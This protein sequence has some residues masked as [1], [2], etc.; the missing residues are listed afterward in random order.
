[1]EIIHSRENAGTIDLFAHICLS[2][3]DLIAHPWYRLCPSDVYILS[4]SILIFGTFLGSCNWESSILL[5]EIYPSLVSWVT[6][7][8][9]W[10][11]NQRKAYQSGKLARILSVK[12]ICKELSS[13]NGLLLFIVWRSTYNW[14]YQQGHI[15][16]AAHSATMN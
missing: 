9:L 12:H 7:T 6:S 2:W 1:M 11:Q 4:P 13:L 10:Q 3:L 15:A 5:D 8:V 14:K 16:R